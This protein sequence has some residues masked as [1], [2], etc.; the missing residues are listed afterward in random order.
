MNGIW[1]TLVVSLGV[2]ADNPALHRVSIFGAT[3][4]HGKPLTISCCGVRQL[5]QQIR[6]VRIP[7]GLRVVFSN[8]EHAER[9]LPVVLLHDR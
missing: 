3:R 9:L 2:W 1:L 8:A 7:S 4:Y 5:S 6:S